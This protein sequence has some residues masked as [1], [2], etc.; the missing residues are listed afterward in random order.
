MLIVG[1]LARHLEAEQADDTRGGV[2]EVVD[3]VRSDREGAGQC[4]DGQLAEKQQKV[5][6]NSDTARNFSVSGAHRVLLNVFVICDKLTDDPVG[7]DT[8][9]FA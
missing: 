4:A 1:G 5:A 2:R 3:S 9:P 7:H 8:G 6:Q